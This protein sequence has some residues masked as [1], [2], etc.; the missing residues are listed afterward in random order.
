MRMRERRCRLQVGGDEAAHS[1]I[2]G[3]VGS[4]TTL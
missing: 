4:A 3:E 1:G 2:D